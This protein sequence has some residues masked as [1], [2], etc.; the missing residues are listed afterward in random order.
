MKHSLLLICILSGLLLQSQVFI[1]HESN[2]NI[3][4]NHFESFDGDGDNDLDLVVGMYSE[5]FYLENDGGTYRNPVSICNT[6]TTEN[7]Q[8]VDLDNDGQIEFVMG[9][10]T[11]AGYVTWHSI[12]QPHQF[13]TLVNEDYPSQD[14]AATFA[15][16]N[17]DDL[18]DILRFYYLGDINA[19]A[20]INEGNMQ[21]SGAI[22]A[23]SGFLSEPPYLR[24]MNMHDVDDDG[25]DDMILKSGLDKI[26]WFENNAGVISNEHVLLQDINLA[27]EN[28]NYGCVYQDLNDDGVK[29]IGLMVMYDQFG[30][31]DYQPCF[32]NLRKDINGD[33]QVNN[34]FEV[35]GDI[36][37]VLNDELKDWDGDNLPDLP[38]T[39]AGPYYTNDIN[40]FVTDITYGLYIDLNSTSGNYIALG[41]V[42]EEDQQLVDFSMDELG[43][44]LCF[45]NISSVNSLFVS[46]DSYSPNGS[47]HMINENLGDVINTVYDWDGDGDLDIIASG[48]YTL[49]RYVWLENLG[50]GQYANRYQYLLNGTDGEGIM[51][52][53]QLDENPQ[54]DIIIRE[55]GA[56]FTA[57][58]RLVGYVRAADNALTEVFSSSLFESTYAVEPNELLVTDYNLDGRDDLITCAL[59]AGGS[60]TVKMIILS[61]D[62]AGNMTE[63]IYE[64]PFEFDLTYQYHIECIDMNSDGLLDIVLT[65]YVDFAMTLYQSMAGDFLIPQVNT[66]YVDGFWSNILLDYDLDGN[67]D[68]VGISGNDQSNWYCALG[69]S[70]GTFNT[71]FI[72]PF[73]QFEI[74]T[75]RG[76]HIDLNLDGIEE[77]IYDNNLYTR[78]S[79]GTF[80]DAVYIDM[81]SFPNEYPYVHYIFADIDQDGLPDIVNDP[82]YQGPVWHQNNFD[83]VFTLDISAFADYNNNGIQDPDEPA[84]QNLPV[85]TTGFSTAFTDNNG[86]LTH[87]LEEGTYTTSIAYNTNI[88]TI[89]SSTTEVT[90]NSSQPNQNIVFAFQ[91]IGSEI[92]SEISLLLDQPMCNQTKNGYIILN[93]TGNQPQQGTITLH[94]NPD[95][96]IT[97]TYP[98]ADIVNGD[99]YSWNYSSLSPTENFGIHL[100]IAYPGVA[101]MGNSMGATVDVEV[102]DVSTTLEG[103]YIDEFEA[104]LLCAY[105][106]NDKTELIGI[107]EE[108]WIEQNERMRYYIRFQ[109]TGTATAT[110]VRIDDPL[111]SML[112][113]STL[114]PIAS[115]HP[116]SVTIDQTGMASFFFDQIMLPDSATDELNSHGFVLFEISQVPDLPHLSTIENTG[117][118]YFDLNP[119]IITNTSLNTI[120]NCSELST[121]INHPSFDLLVSSLSG[122]FIQ[123]S[124]EGMP[125]VN[126]NDDTLIIDPF[127]GGLY[128]VTVEFSEDCIIQNSIFIDQ[129]E[130]IQNRFMSIYPNPTDDEINIQFNEAAQRQI[131]IN[132]MTGRKVF[133]LKSSNTLLRIELGKLPSGVYEVNVFDI[134]RQQSQSTRLIVR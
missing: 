77:V 89:A 101:S 72:I 32:F 84:L 55:P 124:Y 125:I 95:W 90:I 46:I 11:V 50:N 93:N 7:L 106:P 22:D 110:D 30:M 73:P 35:Q 63:T 58:F 59:G 51:T 80:D 128:T 66:G 4:G 94:A 71:P 49:N 86:H 74:S 105:D 119:A 1:S 99:D 112:D 14:N 107:G 131:D 21:F 134:Q 132:D 130:E 56:P 3:L 118:I 85:N 114:L 116:M 133:C 52:P 109:N 12:N 43:I 100:F 78:N 83:N 96:Y 23:G 33:F 28:T 38:Y 113:W 65:N 87:L 53:L 44:H 120:F 123:W 115:S 57:E 9:N 25:D 6:Y 24:G 15:Y 82:E 117:S 121:T 36:H 29:D 68:L 69:L 91:P 62:E 103:T 13:V 104:E 127:T 111:S 34:F 76:A 19:V 60:L 26:S 45:A 20:Y 18:I 129:V 97:G 79:D 81:I 41:I 102:L 31:F 64:I 10:A 88:W 126:A 92:I 8:I 108:G 98:V 27:Q 37:Y 2:V 16:V 42:P 17:D 67:V 47:V 61:L 40:E 122:P 54:A 48:M 39:I 75:F 5:L 70:D